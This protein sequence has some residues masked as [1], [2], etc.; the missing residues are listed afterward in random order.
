MIIDN[1]R[2]DTN[3]KR[4]PEVAPDVKQ[5]LSCIFSPIMTIS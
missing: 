1:I 3:A 2:L 4:E 5:Y